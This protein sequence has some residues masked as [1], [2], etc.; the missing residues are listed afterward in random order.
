MSTSAQF[1]FAPLLPA[2]LPAPAARWTGLAKYS[3]VG[4]N[5]DP[6][7]VPVDGLLEAVNAVLKREGRNL[8]TYN[9]AHGP[10]GYLPL[11]EFL[12]QKLKRDAAIAC[13][14]DEIMIVSGSLQALDLVNHTLLAKGDTV[15]IEQETYQGSLNRLTRLGVNAVGIP[16]DGEGMRMDAL[17]AALADHKRRG[18]TPKYLYTIPTVQNPTGSIL[19]EGRR[20]EMLRLS[21]EYGVPIF[22]DDCYADLIWSGER[23]PA[24][25]AMSKHGGVIHIG[26]FS[27]SIAPALR[28]GFIV[29]PWEM[30]SRMLALKTDAGSGALEQMVLA[31]YCA[32][33]FAT[34]VPRLTR[35]LRAKLD[36][37][38]EAL[39]EQFGTVAEFEAPKGGIFLWVKLPD[40]VDT[41]K[42]Y[43]AALAA[44]VSINPGPEWSTNKAHSGSRLRLCFASP[45]HQQIREGIAV[46][47][48][49]CRKEFGV[50]T[51]SSNVEKRS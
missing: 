2:G 7:Q 34:H 22:E 31:E 42:L 51:R 45:S 10:Q 33:H 49:V 26:S 24:I 37:L 40:N 8:A 39:N 21:Q 32:P 27:K 50:P 3:F 25:Y 17:A 46:L 43:Q 29:A 19:P 13:T 1:D 12:A 44:G 48:E 15:L 4:G 35:G 20:A 47:A 36:T 23:P 6:E 9:L 38:M 30:M 14:P 16:L 18:I 11:R 28:V 41:M 5:N